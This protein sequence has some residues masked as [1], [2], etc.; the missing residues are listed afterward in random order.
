VQSAPAPVAPVNPTITP[1]DPVV[2]VKRSYTSPARVPIVLGVSARFRRGATLTRSGDTGSVRLFTTRTGSTEF[3]FDG[4][5]QARLTGAQLS[6]T[7]GF[8]L[9][10]E[11]DT[12]TGSVGGYH[13]TLTL[14]AGSTPVGPPAVANLTAVRL[15]LDIFT[16]RQPSGTAPQAL[17]QPPATA[18]AAGTATDKWFGGGLVNVQDAARTQERIRLAV[19]RVEPG[20]FVGVLELRQVAVSGTSVG[21]PVNRARVLATAEPAP[22]ETPAANPHPIQ[23]DGLIFTGEDIFLEGSSV[24]ASQRDTGFQ[25]GIQGASA[26][27]D[28][29]ALTV[30]VGASLTQATALRAVVVKKPHTSPARQVITLRTTAPLPATRQGTLSVAATSGSIRLFKT[31]AGNVEITNTANNVFPGDQLTVGVQVFAE[32]AS[33]CTS[34]DHIQLVLTLGAGS[35]P[36]GIPGS[37]RMTSVELTLDVGMSRTAPGVDPPLLPAAQKGNPGRFVQAAHPRFAHERALLITRPPNPQSFVCDLVLTPLSPTV[38]LF[39]DEAPTALQTP[40]STPD[41]VPSFL[42]VPNGVRHFVQT[43]APSAALRDTGIQLGIVGLENDGD[44]IA[45]T[46]YGLAITDN[47]PPFAT[48]AVRVQIEGLLHTARASFDIG[49]LFGTQAASLFRARADVPGVVGNLVQGQ[50]ISRRTNG[51]VLESHNLNL[52]R[53]S[54]DRFASLPILAIPQDFPRADITFRAPQNIEVMRCQAGGT[55]RL[56]LLGA[57][58]GSGGIQVPVRGRVLELCTVTIQGAAPNI[59]GNLATGNRVMAQAGI[60]VRIL[61]QIPVTNATLLDIQQANCPLTI[62][63][64][65]NRG[66]EET[67]LFAL[68]RSACTSSLIV[69][70]VR[71]NSLGLF[72]CSAFPTGQPGVSVADTATQYTFIHEIGHV[73]TLPHNGTANNLMTGAGTN[74][75]PANPANV[76]LLAGQCQSMYTSGFVVQ[77]GG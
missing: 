8:T 46:G 68:G 73:L 13:L 63:G 77:R 27:G 70:F 32:G 50:L 24:S 7:G 49:D 72:G 14:D 67:A 57:L 35:P 53:T 29:V 44:R 45:M 36:A 76:N 25:L 74:S 18:P 31:A 39:S 16:A 9:F 48:P 33:A 5:D 62:G 59:A 19:G 34:P 40:L 60:E 17:P 11:S 66:T 41:T 56:E 10:A 47:N 26:D 1:A 23:A 69:Y 21:A 38:Q 6:R 61:N 42:T 52:T 22:G 75:L 20:D 28:R 43:S 37:T 4:L 12:P 71:S 2:V 65:T 30:G 51:T 54:G 64:D 15:T 58:A 3:A 55:L